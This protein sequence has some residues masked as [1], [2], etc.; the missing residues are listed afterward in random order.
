MK[1]AEAPEE[2]DEAHTKGKGYTPG[3]Q[4]AR[5]LTENETRDET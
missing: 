3:P 2:D 5:E 4:R 1:D